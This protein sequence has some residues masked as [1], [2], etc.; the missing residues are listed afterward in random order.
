MRKILGIS[1]AGIVI[2]D[3]PTFLEGRSKFISAIPKGSVELSFG[4]IYHPIIT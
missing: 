3:S 2:K 4:P 1:D